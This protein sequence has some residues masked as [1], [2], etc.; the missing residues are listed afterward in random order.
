MGPSFV[1]QTPCRSDGFRPND[2]SR[3]LAPFAARNSV[4]VMI[5]TSRLA[6]DACRVTGDVFLTTTPSLSCDVSAV[7]VVADE[8][9][10]LSNF[11]A[12]FSVLLSSSSSSS[13]LSSPSSSSSSS[14]SSSLP[15]SLSLSSLSSSS[16]S[17]YINDR[18]NCSAECKMKN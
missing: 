6:V 16:E 14:S 1:D 2:L 9:S 12:P 11:F 10:R 8:S 7:V 5:I 13:S 3:Y 18:M 15:L 4:T 17:F